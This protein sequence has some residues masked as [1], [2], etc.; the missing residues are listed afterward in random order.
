MLHNP[1]LTLFFPKTCC[2][3]GKHINSKLEHI[4][5]SCRSTLPKTNFHL[6]K[7]NPLQKLFWG[8]INLENVYSYYKFMESG[9]IRKLIHHLKYK[10]MKEI[11]ITVG[12]LYGSELMASGALEK[13]DCIVPVPIHRRK[14]KQR[15]YNQ[16]HYFAEGLSIASGIENKKQ[17]LQKFVHTSSQTKK[18]RY[19]RWKNVES[20]FRIKKKEELQNKH[21]LLVDDVLTTGATIEA[22]GHKLLELPNVKITA[23]TIACTI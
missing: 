9:K 7:D 11:G 5:I 18:S 2:C 16:S 3:C 17:V 14:Y 20:S 1:F 19:K 22:C 23:A 10:G 21:V 8:R 13:I 6:Y 4:C 12:R 15:G